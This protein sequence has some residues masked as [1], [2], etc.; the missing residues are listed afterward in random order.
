M[1]DFSMHP[2]SGDF[3]ALADYLLVV[4]R[5]YLHSALDAQ[6]EQVARCLMEMAEAPDD[7]HHRGVYHALRLFVFKT[8]SIEPPTE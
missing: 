8:P 7:N 6:R 1:Y 5:K 2:T 4:D 3:R